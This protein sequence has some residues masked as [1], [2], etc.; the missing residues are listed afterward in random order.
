MSSK[1]KKYNRVRSGGV[2][3]TGASV[4]WSWGVSPSQYVDVFTTPKALQNPYY[5]DFMVASSG[6]YD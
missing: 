5:W 6:R 3:S 2:L 1:M 4:P